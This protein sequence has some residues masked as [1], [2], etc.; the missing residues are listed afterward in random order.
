M[1]IL[2][3]KTLEEETEERFQSLIPK[4][5]TVDRSGYT[6]QRMEELRMEPVTGEQGKNKPINARMPG[7][8][9]VPLAKI[10]SRSQAEMIGTPETPRP[11][12]DARI[13]GPDEPRLLKEI[14]SSREEAL[15]RM[16]GHLEF[17]QTKEALLEE[18]KRQ[19]PGVKSW[20]DLRVTLPDCEVTLEALLFEFNALWKR[21]QSSSQIPGSEPQTLVYTGTEFEDARDYYR[22][23]DRD[24]ELK[25]E[26]PCAIAIR[27]VHGDR[28]R[29]YG[30]PYDDFGRTA[31]M[32]QTILGVAVTP[33][34]VALCMIC[35]KISRLANAMKDDSIVDICGYAEALHLVRQERDKRNAKAEEIG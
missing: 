32:W 12:K 22:Y 15:R 14:Y 11:E 28:G 3:P 23:A 29:D 16:H 25:A 4:R 34:Q 13:E 7:P 9:E 33:E 6:E 31:A 5:G 26:G 24:A 17:L 35:V 20:D 10:L 19:W 8:E 21:A 1:R 30:S 18:I 2:N 27:L